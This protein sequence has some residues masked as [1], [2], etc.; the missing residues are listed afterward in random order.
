M[1]EPDPPSTEHLAR[2]AASGERHP[3]TVLYERIAPALYT[4]ADLRLRASLRAH[5]EPADVVQEVW[6][7]AL[8]VF[9]RYDPD[10]VSFRYWVFRVA[11]NVLLEATRKAGRLGGGAPA[12]G[13]TARV[14]LLDGCPDTITGVSHRLARDESFAKF[15]GWVDAL[16]EQDRDLLVHHG[17]EGMTHAQVAVRLGIGEEAATK[18]WQ[19]LRRRME[20]QAVP[21]EVLTALAE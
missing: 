9:D 19:R 20:E 1:Q 7:R 15:R 21:R 10:K 8:E 3:F 13:S 2:A 18:R 11:K 17:M 4:W 14:D 5:V 16:E 6:C 12:P